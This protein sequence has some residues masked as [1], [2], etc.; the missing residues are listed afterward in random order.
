MQSQFQIEEKFA[1]LFSESF[2]KSLFS[3]ETVKTS[4][5]MALNLLRTKSKDNL[6]NSAYTCY[7]CC[8]AHPH[9]N[10]CSWKNNFA[11][12]SFGIYDSHKL[13]DFQCECP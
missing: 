2:Y 4:Y 1:Q 7:T 10:D 11:S 13:H 8:C 6:G 3:G 9:T 5:D 12:T